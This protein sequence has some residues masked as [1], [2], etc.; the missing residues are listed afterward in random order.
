MAE[1]KGLPVMNFPDRSSWEVWLADCCTSSPGIWLKFAKKSAE[2]VTISKPDAIEAALCFG[3]VDGQL[4]RFDEAFWLV[5]F[6]PRGPKSKWS[7]NNRDTALRLIAQG[8]MQAAG[9]AEV[10]KA[11]GDGRWD[12][13]YASQSKA[14]IPAD[15]LMALDANPQAKAFFSTLT[16]ANRFAM[17]YR[18]HDAKTEKTRS[19]RIEKFTAMLAAGEV[20]HPILARKG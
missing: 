6:T 8:R 9:S 11:Q 18:I 13:A 4:D 5:R 20:I 19:A 12:A 10:E 14:E 3:W 15:F 16:G 2:T 1:H 7:Q 17:L